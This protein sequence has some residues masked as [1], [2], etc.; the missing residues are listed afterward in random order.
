MLELNSPEIDNFE[1][2][3]ELKKWKQILS[4]LLEQQEE[5]DES[6]VKQPIKDIQEP[7]SKKRKK[8]HDKLSISYIV[9]PLQEETNQQWKF[10]SYNPLKQDEKK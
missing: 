4:N 7:P 2:E 8:Q 3:K 9:S 10:H 5:E 6:I 1:R